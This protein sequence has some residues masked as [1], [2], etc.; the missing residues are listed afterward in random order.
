MYVYCQFRQLKGIFRTLN[1]QKHPQDRIRVKGYYGG[2]INKDRKKKMYSENL[3]ICTVER[4]NMILN[5]ILLSLSSG[6]SLLAKKGESHVDGLNLGCVV[7]DELHVL[8]NSFNG[9]LL[10]IFIR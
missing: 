9:Y 10:E 7:L 1:R 6:G 3:L 4:A 8:G 5:S 2:V